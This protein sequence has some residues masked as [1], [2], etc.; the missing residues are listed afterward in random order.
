MVK[1]LPVPRDSVADAISKSGAK[2]TAQKL[3]VINDWLAHENTF[4]MSYIMNSGKKDEDKPMIAKNP[5]K[6]E[7]EQDVYNAVYS[8]YEK[9]I[10]QN[11]HDQIF[12]GI[13]NNLLQQF[14]EKAIQNIVY[15]QALGKDEALLQMK[16]KKLHRSR[17][18]DLFSRTKT[19]LMRIRMDL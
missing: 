15:Q 8:E 16:R 18:K 7:H 6:Q 19:L 9:Q 5:Q 12:A 4:D 2:T 11:F 3:L 13:E 17:Q 1:V 10:K 14:Y